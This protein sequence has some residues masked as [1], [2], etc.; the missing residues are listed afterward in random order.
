[1]KFLIDSGA[2]HSCVTPTVAA[3]ASLHVIGLVPVQSTTQQTTVNSYLA[4]MHMP[5]GDPGYFLRDIRFS[6][7]KLG[8]TCDGL[9]GRDFMAFGLF[10]MNGPADTFTLAF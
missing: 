5:V 1:M 10:F 4:D 7:L 2:S 8:T 9:L 6:E 3:A